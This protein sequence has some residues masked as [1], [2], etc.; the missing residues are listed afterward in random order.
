MTTPHIPLPSADVLEDAAIPSVDRI[1]EGVAARALSS[2]IDARKG[3]GMADRILLRGGHVLTV[4]PELGDI[5]G[6]DVLIEG[7]TIAQVGQGPVG[8]RRGDRLHGAAS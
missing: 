7:D 2:R 5:A 1:V 4:D 3:R 8:R 6:G